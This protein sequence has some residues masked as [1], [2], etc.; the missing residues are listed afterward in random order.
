MI[1]SLISSITIIQDLSKCFVG[2]IPRSHCNTIL[3]LTNMYV[4][5]FIRVVMILSG[6]KFFLSETNILYEYEFINK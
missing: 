4:K 5:S 2:H 6:H 3:T 1:N